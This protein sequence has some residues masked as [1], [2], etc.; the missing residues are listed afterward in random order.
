[1]YNR[2]CVAQIP[3]I[4]TNGRLILNLFWITS[5]LIKFESLLNQFIWINSFRINSELISKSLLNCPNKN[6]NFITF[7]IAYGTAFEN[8]VH[9][10]MLLQC[11]SF[12]ILIWNDKLHLLL[13]SNKPITDK[14]L[15][16]SCLDDFVLTSD[17]NILCVVWIK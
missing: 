5:E 6:E 14:L 13:L 11:W 2:I 16:C 15:S 10:H 8:S 17:L 9:M 1:M 12:K 7:Q 4:Y 3:A